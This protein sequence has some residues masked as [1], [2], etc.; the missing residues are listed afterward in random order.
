MLRPRQQEKRYNKEEKGYTTFSRLSH[1]KGRQTTSQ[2]DQC[3]VCCRPITKGKVFCA[4]DC[5]LLLHR[6]CV[7][8][9][10]QC[11]RSITESHA[12]LF[13][14][15]VRLTLC[16]A[17]EG[18]DYLPHLTT[19]R[20]FHSLPCRLLFSSTTECSYRNTSTVTTPA[21]SPLDKHVRK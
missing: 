9:S 6:Y 7:G 1:Q 19:G 11:Y 18:R 2:K 10:A 17:P 4:G 13:A 16:Q 3:C 12:A 21:V 14:S 8:V 5:Q 20:L 15:R